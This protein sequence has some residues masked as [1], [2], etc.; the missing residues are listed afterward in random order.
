MEDA[1][2]V[3]QLNRIKTSGL[4]EGT[5]PH[6]KKGLVRLLGSDSFLVSEQEFQAVLDADYWDQ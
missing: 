2:P 1:A 4:S 3:D 6:S 5:S